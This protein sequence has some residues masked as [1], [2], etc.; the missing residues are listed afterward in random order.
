VNGEFYDF[1][2]IRA[3]LQLELS[4]EATIAL[5]GLWK[6]SVPTGDSREAR[7]HREQLGG[8]GRLL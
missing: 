2:R 5:L 6:T 3:G 8:S 4:I 7:R 1:E